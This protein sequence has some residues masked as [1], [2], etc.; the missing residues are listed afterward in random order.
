MYIKKHKSWALPEHYATDEN[1]YLNRR[2]L[3]AK[4]GIAGAGLA[5][6][7]LPFAAAMAAPITGFPAPQNDAYQLDRQLTM[8]SEA[9]TYTNFYE[10]GSSKNIWRKAQKLVTDPWMVTID[11]LIEEEMVL[12]A[13][14]LIK[15]MG[16]QEERLYRHRCVEAWAMAVPWTGSLW[17]NW[18]GLPSQ[19]RKQNSSV[20]KLFTIRL[21][22]LVSAR[23]GIPGPILK[24]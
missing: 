14:D 15:K 21:L 19:R 23:A 2:Q 12:D 20:W 9:T 17:P 6:S 4:M 11:G 16:S 22:P 24:G 10:F 3:L 1:I 18:C 8:E 5:A 13:A 7:Q